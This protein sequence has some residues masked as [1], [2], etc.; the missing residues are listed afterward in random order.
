MRMSDE[1][2]ERLEMARRVAPALRA[3]TNE[4][5]NALQAFEE[6]Y[7]AGLL[8]Y[9]ENFVR[10]VATSGISEELIRYVIQPPR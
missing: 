3:L 5:W 9:Y 4:Q 2:R 7:R 8:T 1:E 10:N 6:S